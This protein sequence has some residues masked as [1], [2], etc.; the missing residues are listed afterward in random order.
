M[1]RMVHP[2]RPSW[3][4][5]PPSFAGPGGSPNKGCS[6]DGPRRANKLLARQIKIKRKCLV[7]LFWK[8]SK[9][10]FHHFTFHQI[11]EDPGA[12]TKISDYNMYYASFFACFSLSASLTSTAAHSLNLLP[13]WFHITR[14]HSSPQ[15]CHARG[16]GP[17]Q[18][19]EAGVLP[20]LWVPH[21]SVIV[22]L[23]FSTFHWN[24]LHIA[25][26]CDLFAMVKWRFQR[27]SDL[28]LGDQKITLNHLSHII[29]YHPILLEVSAW[30]YP[31]ETSPLTSHAL[32]LWCRSSSARFQSW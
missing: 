16:K 23:K 11:C 26:L 10:Y 22:R 31:V 4:S 30:N 1:P 17:I 32:W 6:V 29:C 5:S 18:R 19:E 24:D 8:K 28:Q 25:V 12:I 2:L 21:V 27:L 15:P 13:T 9:W 3:A 7:T 14:P 20:R